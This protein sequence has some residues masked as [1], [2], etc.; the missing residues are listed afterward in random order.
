MKLLLLFDSLSLCQQSDT[1]ID[2]RT[3][4]VGSTTTGR[5]YRARRLSRCDCAVSRHR[6]EMAYRLCTAGM[7]IIFMFHLSFWVPRAAATSA[8]ASRST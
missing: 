4:S 8:Y 2:S 5:Q 6:G 1:N 7:G 3:L